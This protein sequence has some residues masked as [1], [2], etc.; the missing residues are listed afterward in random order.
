MNKIKGLLTINKSKD[1]A[2]EIKT[3]G[4]LKQALEQDIMRYENK[5]TTKVKNN[6]KWL[7][8]CDG[9]ER[10]IVLQLASISSI[11][12]IIFIVAIFICI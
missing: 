2:V 8:T 1:T 4:D 5:I 10:R 7:F 9:D 11:L 6:L 12:A 3:I